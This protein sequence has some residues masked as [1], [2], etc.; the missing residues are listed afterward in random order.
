MAKIINF[1]IIYGIS[2]Y[3][4]AKQL[5]VS[6]GEA[7]LFIDNYFQKFPNI[8]DFMKLTT[9]KAKKLGFVENLF[10]RKSHIKDI[11]AKNFML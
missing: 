7:K 2:Q 4:L 10:G 11:N 8:N 9:D 1:G 3:G 6:N 5:G